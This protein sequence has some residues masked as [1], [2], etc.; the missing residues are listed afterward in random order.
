MKLEYM[1]TQGQPKFT[2]PPSFAL[3]RAFVDQLERNGCLSASRVS[4]VR[5]SLSDAERAAA[6]AR[7]GQLESLAGQIAADAGSSCDKK[8]IGMLEKAVRDLSNVAM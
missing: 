2:W 1:N 4:A 6:G 5:Q 7:R 8:R 3:A